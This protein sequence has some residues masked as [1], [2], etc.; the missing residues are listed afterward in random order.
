MGTCGALS[1]GRKKKTRRTRKLR[2]G[3]QYGPVGAIS[4]GAMEW[5]GVDTSAPYSSSSGQRVHDPFGTSPDT[6]AKVTGGRRKTR[7][8]RKGRKGKKSRKMRGGVSVYNAGA[9]GAAFVGGI[10]GF[11]TGSQ[12]YGAYQGYPVKVPAD[13]P[14]R[15]GKDG[16]MQV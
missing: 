6:N 15:T 8:T 14:H 3:V 10:P 5:S 9:M 16:V 13:I 7:K 4:P 12:T 11:P 1:G 2:G